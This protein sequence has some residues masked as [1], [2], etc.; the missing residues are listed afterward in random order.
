MSD[1]SDNYNDSNDN[2]NVMFGSGEKPVHVSLLMRLFI[3]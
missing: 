3:G 2:L 1:F